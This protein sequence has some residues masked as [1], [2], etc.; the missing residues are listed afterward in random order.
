M[1]QQVKQVKVSEILALLK[2]GVT[3]R[4]KEDLGFGSLE[5]MYSLTTSELRELS[6]HPKIKGIKTKIPTLLIIDDTEE[7]VN[8]LFPVGASTEK[9]LETEYSEKV[10]EIETEKTIE[11]VKEIEAE[12]VEVEKEIK[13]EVTLIKPQV[14][15]FD[16]S[17]KSSILEGEILPFM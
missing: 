4:K 6:E 8:D 1:Q 5:E 16:N 10:E 11:E 9:S 2:K 12:E 13:S 3:R 17:L 15:T 7:E 14:N